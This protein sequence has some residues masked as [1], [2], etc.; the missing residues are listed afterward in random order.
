MI[1]EDAANVIAGAIWV[2]DIKNMTVDQLDE[3]A[4]VQ[5]GDDPDVEWDFLGLSQDAGED[6]HGVNSDEEMMY[7]VNDAGLIVK[8]EIMEDA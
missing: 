3:L 1:D 6:L 2:E 7:T 4:F 8:M 5:W